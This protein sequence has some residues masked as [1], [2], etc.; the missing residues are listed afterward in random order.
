[1]W[2]GQSAGLPPTSDFGYGGLPTT[3]RV[4][5]DELELSA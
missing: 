1:M 2:I 5:V 4:W 3:E